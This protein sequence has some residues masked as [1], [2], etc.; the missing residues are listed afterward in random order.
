MKKLFY[1]V[2]FVSITN[3]AF[4]QGTCNTALPFCTGTNYTFPASTNTPPPTG[5]NFGCLGSQP[6]PAFYYMEIDNPGN[7]TINI[8]G[9]NGPPGTTPIPGWGGNT[10]DIDFICWGPFTNPATMCN[11]LTAANIVDCSYSS[12]WN[13]DCDITGASNGDYYVLL[14]TNYS[15]NPCNINFSQTSGN[16]TTNC[17]IL[18]GDAGDDNTLDV[19]DTDSPFNMWNQLLGNP[20]NGGIWYN[21]SW[22]SISNQFDPANTPSG[23]YAY[24]VQGSSTACPNDT[25]FITVNVNISPI[26]SMPPF[27]NLCDNDQPITLNTATPLGGTYSVNGSNLTTFTPSVLNVGNNTIDYTYTDGN[28]C[29]ST[30]SQNLIVNSSPFA[31]ATT[32]NASCNGFTNGSA[33]LNIISGTA[34][35]IENWGAAS[36]TNLSAGTYGYLVTDANGCS[37]TDSCIIYE[38]AA[39]TVNIISTD[40]LCSGSN[41]GTAVV[42]SSSLSSTYVW[43]SGQTTD[44]IYGLAAGSYSVDVIDQNGCVNTGFINITE[45]APILVTEAI[46]NVSC[47]GGTDGSISLNI[48]GGFTDYTIN[49]AGFSQVLTGGITTYT[50]PNVLPVNIYNYTVTDSNNCSYS[51]SINITSPPPISV[52]EVIN[53]VSCFG[54]NDGSVN[55]S[56]SGGTPTYIEDWG[57]NNSSSLSVGTYNY[58]VTDNNGCIYTNAVSISEPSD[59]Q[60]SAT[61]NNISTCGATDGSID[62]TTLGGSPPYSFNWSSGQNTEDINSLSSGTFTLTVTDANLCTSTH[63]VTLTEPTPPIVSYTQTNTTCNAGS[64]GSID[65]SVSGGLNPYQYSWSNSATSQDVSNLSAGIY[66]LNVTDANNCIVIESITITQ[67]TAIN[68]SSTQTNVTNCNGNDGSIDISTSGGTGIYTYLWSNSATTEDVFNLTAGI[69]SVDVTDANNCTSTF[70][71]TIIEPNGITSTENITNVACFGENSG[72]V[73]INIL[74]GQPPYTENWNGYNPVNL[75]AGNYIYTVTDNQ[76]CSFSNLVVI[77]EP[78]E[79]VVTENITHVLC[80]D[81]NTGSVGL[82]ISGGTSPYNENWGTSNPNTLFDGTYT[83]TLTDAN[84]CT[85]NNQVIISEPDLLSSSIITTNAICFGYNNG[86]A[87]ITTSGGTSPYNTNWFGQ[88]NLSLNSGNY[89]TLITDANGCT[90]TINFSIS[91]PAGIS[92]I[93]DSF[94]TTCF[95]NSDGSAL[96]TI[97]GGFP[98]FTENWFGQN[99]LSL[100]AGNHNFEVIDNNNCIHQG[101]ATIYQPLDITTNKITSDVLCNGESNGTAS[102]QISGGTIPYSENWNGIDI[103]QLP[104]GNYTYTI[105]D[106]NGCTFTDYV[107]IDEPDLLSV[108]EV[109]TD[110]NCFNSNNGKALLIVSGGTTPYTE[111]W[112]IENPFSLSAGVYYYTVSDLNSCSISD[113]VQINQGNE[114]FMNFSVESPICIFDTSKATISIINPNSESY[115]IEINDGIITTNYLIDSVGLLIPLENQ[116]IFNPESSKVVKIVSITDENG[117]TSSVNISD[118]IIVNPL[119]FLSLDIPNFCTQ[120]TSRIINQAIPEGGIYFIDDKKTSFFD[121]ENMEVETYNIRYEYTNPITGCFNTISTDIKINESPYADFSFGPQPANIDNPEIEFLNKSYFY[122]SQRWDLG[123]GTIIKQD[124]FSHIFSDTGSFFTQLYIENEY[125]CSDSITHEIIIYPVFDINIPSAFTPNDDGHNDTF[126]PVLRIGGYQYYHMKIFNQWGGVVFNQNNTFWDGKLNNKL[127]PNGFY[128]YSI[129]VYD[130]LNKPHSLTGGFIL[131]K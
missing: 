70:N 58:T 91:E 76:N 57:S 121:I 11:Q 73:T 90:N 3:I 94:Q 116:I 15:N 9:I 21:S 47:D 46:N 30:S 92:V 89:S 82:N 117:C 14:I 36:P 29:S 108:Q 50:T 111:N 105:T 40:V 129:I 86:T 62:I 63:T 26:V 61:Q 52:S 31:T 99:P 22:T 56:I 39:F 25:S 16:A 124:E 59:I 88:N 109:I 64:D 81:E 35:Y 122:N 127:C 44:S 106:N 5:A 128:T 66:T 123:D 97:S 6:N 53:N 42:S 110:A 74:G 83:Y 37:F 119:P 34:P 12:T 96:L 32:T 13:E 18:G 17:C 85:F 101:I 10:N 93:I 87:I 113:S 68:V 27:S 98:P 102:L 65:V 33:I 72:S 126:G 8:Q 20:D 69:H 78:Q 45:P 60:I 55:L 24:V 95:G 75:T 43:S 104:K 38:P 79:L 103:T 48:S 125:G 107:I 54:F 28:G 120:D 84:G 77:T 7:M 23:T 114:I 100:T 51:S 112:G 131:T 118:S 71:F 2:L 49:V 1:I 19:C 130:F 115:T 4:T 80:K 67:P 41:D